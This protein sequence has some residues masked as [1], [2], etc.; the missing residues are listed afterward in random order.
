MEFVDC[1]AFRR[2]EIPSV[3]ERP[4]IAQANLLVLERLRQ[5]YREGIRQIS[6]AIALLP[7]DGAAVS[8][9]QPWC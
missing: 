7:R 8:L 2:G 4:R 9:S 3:P 1:E 6:Q 5:K